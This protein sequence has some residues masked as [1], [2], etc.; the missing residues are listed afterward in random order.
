MN[1]TFYLDALKIFPVGQPNFFT[2]KGMAFVRRLD[3]F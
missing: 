1:G 2:E 3:I